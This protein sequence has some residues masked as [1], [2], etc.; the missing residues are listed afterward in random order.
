[1]TRK[2]PHRTPR[3]EPEET[4]VVLPHAVITVTE[5]GVLNVTLDGADVPHPEGTAWTRSTFG[6]LLDALTRDRTTTVRI[7]VHENDGSM[8]TDVIRARR[9]T[10]PG[11][12]DAPAET[13]TEPAARATSRSK[14][15]P[16]LV[17]VTGEGFVPGE[18]VAAAVIVFHTDATS[19]GDA[20]ALLDRER[21]RSL[22]S[23]GGEV[24]LFG[25]I[26]GTIH[27]R[28]LP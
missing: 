2:P 18:D 6:P 19:T 24:M 9:R 8:F 13:E 16:D 27:V 11:P 20:R 21:L 7:E 28:R 25:R 17:E 12:P 10:T 4:P 23:G 1:M 26:S 14:R 3:P 5:T 15:R 22:L